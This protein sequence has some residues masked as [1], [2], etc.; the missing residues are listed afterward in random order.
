MSLTKSEIKQYLN[1]DIVKYTLLEFIQ[2]GDY[3]INDL[4]N[5]IIQARNEFRA[6]QW[7]PGEQGGS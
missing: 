7:P 1:R 6:E 4:A 3:D 5:A 2:E